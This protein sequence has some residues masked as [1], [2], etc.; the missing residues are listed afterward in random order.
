L[1]YFSEGPVNPSPRLS[2]LVCATPRS[3]S[4]LLCETLMQTGVAGCPREYF[5]ALP[6]TGLPRQ[7]REYVG[8]LAD[9]EVDRLLPPLRCGPRL[10]AFRERLAAAL[11]EGTTRNGVFGCKLMWGYAPPFLE[12]VGGAPESVLP[13]VHYVLVTREDK[14]RQAVSLWRALQTQVWSTPD[15]T[16]EGHRPAGARRPV[17]SRAAID[18][19]HAQLAEHEGAWR[20]WFAARGVQPLEL[21]Y[22]QFAERPAAAVAAVLEHLRIPAPGGFAPHAPLRRQA[23]ALTDDWVR[24]HAAAA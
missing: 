12:A 7:P 13:D 19:L 9:P 5:E 23:D 4:T 8:D 20:R 1:V 18:A 3:G 22:E 16:D 6:A 11:R 17:Y 2:Y 10:P 21:R 15:G 14:L 24:R